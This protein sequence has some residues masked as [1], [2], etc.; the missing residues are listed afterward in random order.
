MGTQRLI[1][2]RYSLVE[3]LPG[4]A[5]GIGWHA[6]D[7]WS[8]QLVAITRVPV[9]GLVGHELRRA[10]HEIAGEVRVLSGLQHDRLVR[11]MEVVLDGDD[12]WV[13]SELIAGVTMADELARRGA[14]GPQ[15]VARWGRD[16]ADT[17]AVAHGVGVAH[18]N[19]HAGMVGLAEDGR[20]LLGGFA[21]TVVT[22]EGLRNGTP[23]HV[24]PE[25]AQGANPSPAAD[26]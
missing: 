25:V 6:Q 8:G 12:L 18:R 19:L 14:V 22:L 17:L 16:V 13:V 9:S 24:A 7:L 26:V 2:E 11:A 20:A 10:Y 23:V 4:S 5:T 21:T 1:A 3:P 15:E